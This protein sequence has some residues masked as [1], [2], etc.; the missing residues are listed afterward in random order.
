MKIKVIVLAL[1]CILCQYT[2]AQISEG[3]I[4]ISFS[5]NIDMEKEKIPVMIMPVVDVKAL[6]EEDEKKRKEDA[7]IPFRFGY[8]IDVDIDIK[9]DGM[10]KELSNGDNLWLLKIHCPDAFSIN[11]IYNN[12]MLSKGAKFFIYNE[13]KTMIL[14]AFTPEVSNSLHNEFAT[15][16]VQG[17][18]II[19]EYYEPALSNNGY[20]HINKVI[21]GYQNIFYS[22]G[23]GTSASCNVDV[24]CALASNWINERNAVAMILVDNNTALCSGCLINNAQQNFVPYFLT[25]RHCYF[26]NNG[27]IQTTFPSTSIFRFQYWKPNC[28]SGSPSNWKSI[29]GATLRAHNAP[30]D[31]ALL[32][33]SSIPPANW[34]LYYAG[35]DRTTVPAQN[36][37]GI[38][39]PKGD[40][41]KISYESH[42]VF[43][44]N[45][46]IQGDALTTWR[47]QHFEDGTTQ[48]GS[49]GSPLFNQNYKIVGQVSTGPNCSD[50]TCSCNNRSANYGRF[51][52]SWTGGGTNSTRLSNWLDP[53]N[54]GISVLEGT[55]I[56][57]PCTSPTIS[58]I[59]QT[60]N[61]NQTVT[62]CNINVQNV[63]VTNNKKLILDAVNITTVIKDF[64]VK[65]GSELEIK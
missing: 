8:A 34:N 19:L 36:V 47:V 62:S 22:N 31:F 12:F 37:T 50:N 32:E 14:G 33:L 7:Q 3:G 1:F 24:M 65:L 29:T 17:N 59:N 28:G 23:L 45:H 44:Q 48:P 30:T 20:I 64:E 39:H 13:D 42:P 26:Q 9:K 18:T 25:A 56:I 15:D 6:L 21:H 60:V 27:N 49:S 38:H 11:L 2:F 35:W 63:I 5:L 57:P 61:T 58:F 4:P 43:A 40:A 41:M 10:K 55:S 52:M 53:N 54:T 51:D 46:P 16:L